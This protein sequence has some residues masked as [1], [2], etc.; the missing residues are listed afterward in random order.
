MAERTVLAF[1]R[2]EYSRAQ[3]DATADGLAASLRERGV[4][5][6]DRVALMSSNRPE[7]VVAVLGIWRLGAAVV[8]MSPAWKR[9]EV[10]HALDVTG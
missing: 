4:L 2:Q 9:D 5:P 1:D 10:V 6:G 7:F 3:L 8:L